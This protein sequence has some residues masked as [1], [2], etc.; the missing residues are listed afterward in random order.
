MVPSKAS[1]TCASTARSLV[2]AGARDQIERS[3]AGLQAEARDCVV[4]EVR[5]RRHA[6][7][8]RRPMTVDERSEHDLLGADEHEAA[9]VAVR[10]RLDRQRAERRHGQAA[11]EVSATRLVSPRKW[12]TASVSGCW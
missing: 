10:P 12:A 8:E 11:V 2:A 6:G 1:V 7:R 3:R 9:A 4:P 5:D